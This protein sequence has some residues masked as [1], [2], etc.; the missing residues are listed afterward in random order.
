MRKIVLVL[1]ILAAWTAAQTQQTFTFNN[2]SLPDT[3]F[4]NG[5]NLPGYFTDTAGE[6]SL[7]L[8]NY[9]DPTYDSWYGFAYSVWTDDTTNSYLNQW[10]TYAGY[11]L[12]SVFVIGYIGIDWLN[13]YSNIPAGLKF[14]TAVNPQGF[15]ISNIT[16][17]ALTIR[18]GNDFNRPFYSGDYFKLIITGFYNS[19][20]TGSV[21]H[22]LAD[23]TNGKTFIQK[24]WSYVDLSALGTVDSLAFNLLTTDTGSY[25]A[26]TP[27][28]FAMDQLTVEP[29]A[30][31]TITSAY[32]PIK[33]YPNPASDVVFLGKIYKKAEIISVN[34]G[35]VSHYANTDKLNVG[36][37][38]AGIYILK[39][40]DGKQWFVSKI[41]VRH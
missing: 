9:Y 24:D 16:Y 12:D 15:Y 22:Y 5:S 33:V 13:D 34:G 40:Y 10:S 23:Y 2:L 11:L 29:A 39:L 18:D 37:L 36:L 31:T 4:C 27:L 14:G 26:N 1:A 32:N 28:Y 7:K 19:Q 35:K 21:E 30:M 25:G 6:I 8:Y 20:P 41:I 3:G 38:P 17:A